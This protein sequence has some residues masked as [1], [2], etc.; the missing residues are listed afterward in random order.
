MAS[1][2][3]DPGRLELSTLSKEIWKSYSVDLG[4]ETTYR[5]S[6][7]TMLCYSDQEIAQFDAWKTAASGVVQTD[8]RPLTRAEIIRRLGVQPPTNVVGAYCQPSDGGIDPRAA[9]SLLAEAAQ[10]M[11]ATIHEKCAVRGIETSGGAVSAVVTE[12]GTMRAGAVVVA[13]GVWSRLFC[14][15]L[16]ID[17]PIAS[18]SATTARLKTGNGGPPGSGATNGFGWHQHLDG[19]YTFGTKVGTLSIVPDTF[20]LLPRF[21]PAYFKNRGDIELDLDQDFFKAWR[22]PRR[23][24][25]DASSPFEEHRILASKPDHRNAE[26][27]FLAFLDYFGESSAEVVESWGAVMD[28]TPDKLPIVGPIKSLPGLF[29]CTGFSAHGLAMGPAAGQLV[30]RQILG[31]VPNVNPEPYQPSRFCKSHSTP[32]ANIPG[33]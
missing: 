1:L 21:L 6:G 27:A 32:A 29:V 3:D 17:L 30:A 24:P 15:S 23:W 28:S 8:A 10:Q 4:V 22:V 12:A 16:G 18:V 19:T 31:L 33:N 2:G 13:A 7:L 20:R 25:M 9:T 26:R 11:G 5:Q 14:G